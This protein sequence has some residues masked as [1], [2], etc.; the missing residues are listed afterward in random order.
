MCGTNDFGG[1]HS[2]SNVGHGLTIYAVAI[3]PVIEVGPIAPGADPQGNPDAEATADAM[4]HETVEAIT[5]PQGVGWMDPNG[6]EVADKCEFGPQLGT[7]LGNAG[8]DTAEFN[9][10]ING[11][12]YVEQDM[13][14][15]DDSACVQG[16]SSTD[17]PLPLPQVNMTQFSKTI[18]GN[19][20]SMSAGVGVTVSL[21][22]SDA[23]GNPVTVSS[24]S[25][26]TADGTW[27]VPLSHAVGDDRDEIDVDY[28]GAGAPTPDHQVILTGNG[29]NPF[30][31]SGWTGW[32]ALDDGSILTNDDPPRAAHRSRSGRA[33]RPGPRVS[34]GRSAPSAARRPT[35]F[36]STS[37]DTADAPLTAAV[38][39]S[40]AETITTND[41]RAYQPADA[42]TN[43]SVPGAVPNA[44]GGLV[45]LTIPAGEPD[46]TSLFNFPLAEV[47][48]VPFTQTGFP[49]C[50]ADLGEQP[51]T[52]T[53][54][55]PTEH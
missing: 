35:D 14:S 50:S 27:S 37:G 19:I 49:T 16:T 33:S 36:C 24:A 25:T 6:F 23:Q 9:Q 13:W 41:N 5:D 38:T 28:S 44:N 51:L 1:Y 40:D 18:T 42:A 43:P 31:E 55:R 12:A 3:D 17:N 34:V 30:T 53:G 21:L 46:S 48:G 52:C 26:T 15:N 4:G 29:G 8:P 7:I 2:L 54:S 20:A 32:S 39:P 47:T 22:R 11:N 45:S 10:Q